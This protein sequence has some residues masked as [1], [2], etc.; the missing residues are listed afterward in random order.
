MHKSISFAPLCHSQHF[1]SLESKFAALKKYCDLKWKVIPIY[2]V[3]NGQCLCNKFDCSAIG[4]HPATKNG[5]YDGSDDYDSLALIWKKNP[6]L[7]IGVVTGIVSGIVVLDIDKKNN[8]YD[9]FKTLQNQYGFSSLTRKCLSGGG[10]FHLYFKHPGL[11]LKNKAGILPGIDFR[12]DGGYIVAPP[13]MHKSGKIYGWEHED[14]VLA[15]LP[16]L[17]LKRLVE[18]KG[19][20]EGQN[21][22]YS[23]V[24]EG[25][26]NSTLLS[27]GGFLLSKQISLPLISET[28]KFLNAKACEKPLAENEVHKIST[29]LKKYDVDLIWGEP[30][31][32]EDEVIQISPLVLE[33]IP[34]PLRAWVVDICERKQLDFEFIIGPALVSIAA[35]VGAKVGIHPLQKDDWLVIPNLWGFLVAD[36][37]SM[38]SP[39]MAEALKAFSSLEKEEKKVFQITCRDAQKEERE[40]VQKVEALKK[41]LNINDASIDFEK[42]EEYQADICSLEGGIQ[43]KKDIKEKRYKTNDPTVEKLAVILK[44]NPQGILLF[45]DELN[46][47]L[48]SLGKVGREGNREFYLETWNGFGSFSVDR[49]GRGSVF[50]ENMC[51][52]I[53]GGIQPIKLESYIEQHSSSSGDD[54]FLE[55]FQIVFYPSKRKSFSLIDRRPDF[56]AYE[57]TLKIFKFLDQIEGSANQNSLRFSKE[58]Q[59]ISDTWRLQLEERILNTPLS[60]IHRSHISKYRS[61]M[62]SLAVLF[63]LIDHAA[64]ESLP[65]K[66]DCSYAR[67]AIT[68]CQKLESH[69]IRIYQ[70]SIHNPVHSAKIL[71]EKIKT[72]AI[73]DGEK[74]RDIA[75]KHWKGLNTPEDLRTA[76]RTLEEKKWIKRL[77]VKGRGKQSEIIRINPKLKMR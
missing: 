15:D 16:D 70:N 5:L 3:K 41:C 8:G 55:R 18:G 33:D 26:R 47:W 40:A 51:L 32:F 64:G 35:V 45:R 1:F 75:R 24:K 60:I 29:S 69:L 17:L 62:P 63:S 21:F 57:R 36:P 11:N 13:S 4:K 22:S 28:L 61:L 74:L 23:G 59:K 20:S 31:S 2:G 39:A 30:E 68:W 53:Y 38:K 49:I 77:T 71:A 72:G 66:V 25:E 43:E 48:D 56:E 19:N 42:I 6:E 54:G 52:S 12:G 37:G 46:G 44:D 76:L 58:A 14:L 27:I 34:K 7:N 67:Q 50:V 73:S 10:G 65:K 9:S